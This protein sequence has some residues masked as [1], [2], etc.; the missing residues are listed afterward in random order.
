VTHGDDGLP[1]L[2]HQGYHA[3]LC[4]VGPDTQHPFS[5]IQEVS[6]VVERVEANDIG[7]C[8]RLEGEREG[9]RERRRER[10]KEGEREGGRERRREREKEGEREGGREGRR[11]RGKEGER[12]GG[13]EGRRE[14]EKEGEREGGR[15]GRND[16]K[17][18]M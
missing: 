10:E 9:G 5:C 1:V 2:Q 4:G 15:E 3:A 14:R 11:E 7:T 18:R 13:R 8:H 16:R 17:G 6:S 12:E